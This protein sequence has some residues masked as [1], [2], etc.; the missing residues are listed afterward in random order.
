VTQ[1]GLE[2]GHEVESSLVHLIQTNDVPRP[3]ADGGQG[4]RE[5]SSH[6]P[7]P[8]GGNLSLVLR[9]LF[10]AGVINRKALQVSLLCKDCSFSPQQISKSLK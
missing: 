9:L 1:S 8:E 2:G 7:G 4:G 6:S 3:A 10:R 5:T